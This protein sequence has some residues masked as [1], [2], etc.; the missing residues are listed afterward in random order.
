MAIINKF[1]SLI[2]VA[3]IVFGLAGC[4]EVT[5]SP[6][7][8]FQFTA[9]RSEMDLLIADLRIPLK[10]HAGITAF[11]SRDTHDTSGAAYFTC[12]SLPLLHLMEIP[13]QHERD[14]DAPVEYSL[15]VFPM[16][17]LD[18]K[19]SDAILKALEKHVSIKKNA[20]D[21]VRIKY[22]HDQVFNRESNALNLDDQCRSP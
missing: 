1:L 8:Q 9:K 20:Y 15:D 6:L 16:S 12:K 2:A 11:Y 19:T 13:T 14:A 22:T 21:D 17:A 7:L 4:V 10:N 18:K 5:Y 3:I